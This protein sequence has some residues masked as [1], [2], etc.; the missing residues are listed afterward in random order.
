MWTLFGFVQAHLRTFSDVTY[1]AF[2]LSVLYKDVHELI[3]PLYVFGMLKL[4]KRLVQLEFEHKGLSVLLVDFICLLLS[5]R[6]PLEGVKLL[7][8][9]RVL[10]LTR[11][12]THVSH[13]WIS[14][15][16]KSVE[17]VDSRGPSLALSRLIHAR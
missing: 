8:K 12:S 14:L 9:V 10:V 7:G 16:F 6:F 2:A 4:V 3:S 1:S 13:A 11:M 17:G 15:V 5:T